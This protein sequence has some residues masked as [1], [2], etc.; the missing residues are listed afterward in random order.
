MKKSILLLLVTTTLMSFSACGFENPSVTNQQPIVP[1]VRDE[2]DNKGNEL[3]NKPI[4]SPTTEENKAVPE[5]T[6]NNDIAVIDNPEIKEDN[7]LNSDTPNIPE[8]SVVPEPI[9][10]N[11]PIGEEPNNSEPIE[12]TQPNLPEILPVDSRIEKGIA[13]INKVI[14]ARNILLSKHLP[15][16]NCVQY[17]I[18]NLSVK[19]DD[20]P[21]D[22]ETQDGNW[23]TSNYAFYAIGSQFYYNYVNDNIGYYDFYDWITKQPSTQYI[24]DNYGVSKKFGSSTNDLLMMEAIGLSPY[25]NSCKII[26][27]VELIETDEYTI[28]NIK[29]DYAILLECDGKLGLTAVFDNKDNLLNICSSN[30]WSIYI[31]SF[32]NGFTDF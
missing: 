9:E 14:K 31:S 10:S 17:D 6:L 16:E 18:E 4:S 13:K 7:A 11:A 27:P 30:D 1:I 25:L 15:I 20:Y 32:P 5:P 3:K 8:S 19:F 2:L 22:C 23:I 26:K 24:L 28:S 12:T 21:G 29:S